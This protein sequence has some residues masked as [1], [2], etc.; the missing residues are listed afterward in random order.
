MARWT[1][2]PDVRTCS[3]RGRGAGE[4]AGRAPLGR[5]STVG[6]DIELLG[7]AGAAAAA[8]SFPTRRGGRPLARSLPRRVLPAPH[9]EDGGR[10]VEDSTDMPGGIHMADHKDRLDDTT[11]RDADL[12]RTMGEDNAPVS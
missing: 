10:R 8:S 5:P 12:K 1:S 7:S 3:P 2:W 6:A 9:D 11:R 4:S